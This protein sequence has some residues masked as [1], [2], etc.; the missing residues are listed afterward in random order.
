MKILKWIFIV[1]T[2]LILISIGALIIY[3]NFFYEREL[4]NIKSDLN[5]IDGVSVLDIWGHKDLTLEEVSAR[6]RIEGKGEIVLINLSSD[7]YDYPNSVYIKEI[8]GLSFT[9][10]SCGNNLG[11]GSSIDISENS[12]VGKMIGIK[13]ESPKVVIENYDL[14]LQAV[15]SLKQAPDLNYFEHENYERY[16]MIVQNKTEDID[17]LYNLLGVENLA[18]FGR[19]LKWKRSNCN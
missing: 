1:L 6:I 16:L 10:I 11:F 17:P 3:Q 13:F 18:D 15:K 9:S 4:K 7:V 8:G 12:D 19:T 2:L 14:I 5:E